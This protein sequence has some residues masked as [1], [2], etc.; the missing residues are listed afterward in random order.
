M[1]VVRNLTTARTNSQNKGYAFG[2][3]A[4]RNPLERVGERPALS[5]SY[6]R[7]RLE[8]GDLRERV[9]GLPSLLEADGVWRSIWLKEAHHSTALEGNTLDLKQV[10][11]L[12]AEGR[13]V[14]GK[15]LIEYMEVRGYADAATWV[16]GQAISGDFRSGR[17]AE[18]EAELRH[19]AWREQAGLGVVSEPDL[20][21]MAELRDIHRRAMMPVWAVSP[22]RDASEAEGPGSFRQ[23]DIEPFPNGMRPPAWSELPSLMSY[24]ISEVQSL[25]RKAPAAMPEA[26]AHLHARFGQV[27]PFIDGNGRTSRLVLNL[28]LV[29]LGFPPALIY[30]GDRARY[31]A[32]LERADAGDPAPLGE[33]LARAILENLHKFVGTTEERP[34]HLV[35]LHEL[36]T[37]QVS[38][39]ALRVAATRGRLR[40]SKAADGSWL[41][42]RAWVEEYV[43]GRYS[44][45]DRRPE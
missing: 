22:Y 16:Y 1:F 40:A 7:L 23:Q 43:A 26:L 3:E 36:A 37:R 10:A 13:A 45:D 44:R 21:T 11:E 4:S 9:G 34:V 14:G 17:Q 41:S 39:N 42:Q 19:R 29:R 38:A 33:I 32:A 6:E 25:R 18:S 20:V 31:L 2:V 15:E 28:I 12:L 5:A 24:W 35:P 8:I 30:K 27:H